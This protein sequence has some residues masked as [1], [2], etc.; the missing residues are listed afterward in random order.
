MKLTC[1]YTVLLLPWV[2]S[3]THCSIIYISSSLIFLLT[4]SAGFA[5]RFSAEGG[6]IFYQFRAIS[7]R[8][9][10][11]MHLFLCTAQALYISTDLEGPALT[12]TG[13]ELG[14]L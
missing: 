11:H 13:G 1:N 4:N 2:F 7:S 5:Y 6:E 9:T 8:N 10:D 14:L 3:R 12:G